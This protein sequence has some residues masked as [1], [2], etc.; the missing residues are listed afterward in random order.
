MKQRSIQRPA[1]HRERRPVPGVHRQLRPIRAERREL[2]VGLQLW[3]QAAPCRRA[4]GERH[5]GPG[6]GDVRRP[7]LDL[8]LPVDPVRVHGEADLGQQR[9]TPM[10][11]VPEQAGDPGL[12][13]LEQRGLRLP[14]RQ[15]EID[16]VAQEHA[17]SVGPP[18]ARPPG[19][20]A[21]EPRDP[22]PPAVAGP[23]ANL[24]ASTIRRL[25]M[26]TRVRTLAIAAAAVVLLLT[27][28]AC[29]SGGDG[30]GSEGDAA[31]GGSGAPASVQVSLTD[32][33][34]SPEM[35]HVT[36]GQPLTFE[37]SNDGK[38]PHTFALETGSETAET[39]QIAPGASATLEVPALDEGSYKTLCTVPGHSDLGMT[40][41]VMAMAEG[42]G[43]AMGSTGTAAGAPGS[44]GTMSA[45]PVANR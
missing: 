33:A 2:D 32:F 35:I 36:A 12:G 42:S 24:P 28:A 37:V 16:V 23:D 4:P 15:R 26:K 10:L 11:R 19:Q 14:E 45:E 3:E 20:T 30:S 1:D 40:G 7:Q 38:S 5:P 27:A 8:D 31:A 43:T 25:S 22:R 13:P 39:D 21:L 6:P 17:A 9:V 29:S 41:S 44:H 34:I 18:R